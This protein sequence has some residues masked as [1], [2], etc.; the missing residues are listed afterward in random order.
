VY[1]DAQ[2]LR[3]LW[4]HVQEENV[5]FDDISVVSDTSCQ[6]KCKFYLMGKLENNFGRPP[7][8]KI[9]KITMDELNRLTL[10][11]FKLRHLKSANE[12]IEESFIENDEK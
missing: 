2:A 7:D 3:N 12:G 4:S 1:D 6:V 8:E 9:S 11:N 5:E 10:E